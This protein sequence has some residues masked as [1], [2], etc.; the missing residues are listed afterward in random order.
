MSVKSREPVIG[1]KVVLTSDVIDTRIIPGFYNQ[2][3]IRFKGDKGTIH[4]I[5]D[6]DCY[7]YSPGQFNAE[8]FVIKFRKPDRSGR[9]FLRVSHTQLALV[10]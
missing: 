5:N 7:G 4:N 6:N 3:V 10:R 1:D 8:I 9:N 2:H